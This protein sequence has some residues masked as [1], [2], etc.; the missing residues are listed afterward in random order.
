MDQT[1]DSTLSPDDVIPWLGRL[2]RADGRNAL[3]GVAQD[4]CGVFHLGDRI[5]VVS[6]DFLNATPIAEQTDLGDQRTLGR[7]AVAATIAD[8]VGSGAAPRALVAAVTVP[9][10]YPN[11]LFR[12]IMKGI[13]FES[14]KWGAPVLGGDT[15]LGHARAI[16]TCGIGTVES[17]DELFLSCNARPGDTI[18]AS[19][20]LGTCAAATLL[21]AQSTGPSTRVPRWA[22]SAITTPNLPLERS[23]RLASLRIARGGTDVSDGLG[24]DI[25]HL[26]ARSNVGAI[27]DV[28]S[29]PV[30]RVVRTFARRLG[31]PPWAFSFASGGD[32]QFVVTAPSDA[33]RLPLQLGFKKV[34]RIVRGRRVLLRDA[35]GLQRPLPRTGHRDRMG[36][37]FA[38]EIERILREVQE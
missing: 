38:E 15:K 17:V 37:T 27:I 34:G 4:D 16:L 18:L 20:Y 28:E 19:G 29:I 10:G 6:A 22:R 33:L 13:R 3:A 26:C 35:T 12:D 30:R 31:A 25:H 7:L 8:L 23:R 36:T 21:A 9:H 5:V 1:T 32:F 2:F 14:R 11:R 24:I